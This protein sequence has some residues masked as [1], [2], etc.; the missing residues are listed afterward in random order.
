[1][2]GA[3]QVEEK[4]KF[5]RWYA[6]GQFPLPADEA[7]AKMYCTATATLQRQGMEHYEVSS[8]AKPGHRCVSQPSKLGL[9][10]LSTDQVPRPESMWRYDSQICVCAASGITTKVKA[11]ATD[12]CSWT[13]K[14]LNA[15]RIESGRIHVCIISNTIAHTENAG[16][17]QP[18]TP[19]VPSQMHWTVEME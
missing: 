8:Y 2:L 14:V 6:P 4:T 9:V 1:M 11:N 15:Q 3:F 17:A 13:S 5:G 16:S 19:H 7:T 18:R 12:N 10:G